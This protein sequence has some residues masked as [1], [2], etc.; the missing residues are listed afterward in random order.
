MVLWLNAAAAAAAAAAAEVS[1]S[2]C[3]VASVLWSVQI[4]EIKVIKVMG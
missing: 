3:G 1:W 4:D 2:S